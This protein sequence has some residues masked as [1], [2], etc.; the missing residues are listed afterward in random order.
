MITE[1][2]VRNCG[3]V[4]LPFPLMSDHAQQ[5]FNIY[6]ALGLGFG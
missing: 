5:I 6:L 2:P 1:G 4:D 3:S